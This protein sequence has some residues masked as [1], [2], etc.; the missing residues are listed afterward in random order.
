MVESKLSLIPNIFFQVPL[1]AEFGKMISST[2]PSLTGL[3]VIPTIFNYI[4]ISILDQNYNSLVLKD[5]E[6]TISLILE[7]EENE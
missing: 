5:P 1:T 2:T 4:E 6:L 3:S 7:I